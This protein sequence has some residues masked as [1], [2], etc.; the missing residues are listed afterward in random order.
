MTERELRDALR[1]AAPEDDARARERAWQRRAGAPTPS[2][3]RAARAAPRAAPRRAGAG[4]RARAASP[5]PARRAASAPRQRRRA[6]GARRAR[7]R[8]AR[9]AAGARARARRRAAARAGAA[10]SAWVVSRDGAKRRLGD[11]AGASWSPHGLFVVAWRGRELTALEPGGEVRWSLPAPATASRARA[12]RR[13][14]A[15]AIAYLAGGDAAGR[16]RRRHRRP[17]PTAAARRDVAPA[18]RPDAAHV[19]AYVD[20]RD[21]VERRRRRHARARCGAARRCAE[22]AQLAWSPD[23]ARL[24]VATP[25]ALVLFDAAGRRS[26]VAR[27]CRP[28]SVAERRRVGAARRRRSRSCAASPRTA[29]AR[30][31]LLDAARGLRERA[32]FT[33]PGRFGARAWSPGGERLLL[34]LARRRP[35]AVPAPTRR[36]GGVDRRSRT[37]PASS[38][39]ATRRRRSRAGGVVL[40]RHTAR[41]SVRACAAGVLQPLEHLA[42]RALARRAPRRPCSR[43]ST[44]RSPSPPSAAARPARAARGRTSSARPGGAIADRAAA[45]V[46]LRR[47]V[48]LEVVDRVQRPRRRRPARG[49]A[50]AARRRSSSGSRANARA[51]SP[52]TKP[53]SAP[54]VPERG[55]LSNVTLHGPTSETDDAVEPVAAPERPLVDRLDLDE[56]ALR[57]ARGQAVAQ[58]RQR[59]ARTGCARR[60]PAAARR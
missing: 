28:A 9:R 53:S 46:G 44:S 43:S 1:D 3:S 51:S 15:S 20:A 35:V 19:L 7:R 12:G 18:W 55:E 54:G 42:R 21:R 48:H 10:T 11:Y 24:L 4:G 36:R 5:P 16:Q 17:P 25:R 13:S 14:T 27:A 22:P 37:S 41:P 60:A 38:C 33:G 59:R 49:C 40:R 30:S 32:L 8:R 47:P 57:H 58:R 29:A 39:R 45:R 56:V 34:G 52:P 26:Y 6:L 31:L 50:S 23:G 2:T